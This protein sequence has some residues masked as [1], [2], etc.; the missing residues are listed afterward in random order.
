MVP[1]QAELTAGINHTSIREG[2]LPI[3]NVLARW[4]CDVL[5]GALLIYRSL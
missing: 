4:N 5:M 3:F 1:L 2:Y